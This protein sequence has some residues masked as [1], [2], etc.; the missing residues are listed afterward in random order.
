MGNAVSAGFKYFN[1]K[2]PSNCVNYTSTL[3]RLSTLNSSE[4]KNIHV[5]LN[6]VGGRVG[7]RDP[8]TPGLVRDGGRDGVR[9]GG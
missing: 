8:R 7:G 5:N 1:K 2:S 9:D 4:P 6:D 3:S